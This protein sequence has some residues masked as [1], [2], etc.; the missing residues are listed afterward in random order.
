MLPNLATPMDNM[1]NLA[2]FNSSL[3]FHDSSNI[4][5]DT[6][7]NNTAQFGQARNQRF[8]TEIVIKY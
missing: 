8:K 5:I 7:A 1:K 2:T 4:M 6:L 3:W